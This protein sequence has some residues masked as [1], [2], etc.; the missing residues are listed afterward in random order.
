MSIELSRRHGRALARPSTP[1]L[2]H[3]TYGSIPRSAATEGTRLRGRRTSRTFLVTKVDTSPAEIVRRNFDNDPVAYSRTDAKFPHLAR[4]IGEQLMI[5]IEL[6]PVVPVGED[7]GNGTVEF[8][9]F[10][11]GHSLSHSK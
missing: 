2:L 4:D 8:Q 10:F 6:H 7:L 9:Q 11:L 5:V 3:K 1:W